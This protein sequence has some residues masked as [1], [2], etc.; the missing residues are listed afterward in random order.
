MGKAPIINLYPM[1]EFKIA[2]AEAHRQWEELLGVPLQGDTV[3]LHHETYRS[4]A[5]KIQ[6]IQL[7]AALRTRGKEL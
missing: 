1:H 6:V 3:K 7:T 5:D 2:D 4:I